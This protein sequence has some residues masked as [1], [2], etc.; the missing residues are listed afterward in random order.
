MS[1]QQKKVKQVNNQ[2][3]QQPLLVPMATPLHPPSVQ[4]KSQDVLEQFMAKQKLILTQLRQEVEASHRENARIKNEL[5]S[6]T[7][8]FRNLQTL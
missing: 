3:I 8:A 4:A 1:D 7:E 6:K 2:R 5:I